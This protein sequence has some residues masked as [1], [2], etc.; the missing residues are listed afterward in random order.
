MSGWIVM[1]GNV[2]I[3]IGRNGEVVHCVESREDSL[4][5]AREIDAHR[6]S[7]IA[8]RHVRVYHVEGLRV[9]EVVFGDEAGGGR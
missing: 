7:L 1:D 8:S 5:F 9:A 3:G 4:L 6:F 2:G